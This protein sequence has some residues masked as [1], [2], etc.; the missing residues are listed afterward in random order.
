MYSQ[1]ENFRFTWSYLE[2]EEEIGLKIGL[3]IIFN[4]KKASKK[5]PFYLPAELVNF[6]TFFV[7]PQKYPT[8][9]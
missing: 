4:S 1:S 2:L 3:M 6:I 8:C 7:T 5:M 9:L